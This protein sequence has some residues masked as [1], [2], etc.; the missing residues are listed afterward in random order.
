MTEILKEKIPFGKENAI[1]R[2]MLSNELGIS[3]RA[4]REAIEQ[5]RADGM[6]IINIGDGSGYY[7]TNNLEEIAAQYHKDT[8]RALSVLKR[9]KPM[10]DRLKSAGYQV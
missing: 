5:A 7:Q 1:R 6:M 2:E 10:R 9:R 4:M 8:A 3:D